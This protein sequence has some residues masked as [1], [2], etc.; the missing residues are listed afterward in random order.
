MKTDACQFCYSEHYSIKTGGIYEKSNICSGGGN[1]EYSS[2]KNRIR[3]RDKVKMMFMFVLFA[4]IW[5]C[6]PVTASVTDNLRSAAAEILGAVD[7][8]VG[9]SY[10]NAST[11]A[12]INYLEGEIQD[13]KE[14]IADMETV[15]ET[16]GIE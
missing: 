7:A 11:N 8:S 13:L 9:S 3:L 1:S 14:L 4:L 6:I 12:K 10:E 15:I 16:A 5:N 2:L